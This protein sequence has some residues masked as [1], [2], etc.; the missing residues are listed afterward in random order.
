MAI[1]GFKPMVLKK[2]IN[3]VIDAYADLQDAIIQ[4]TQNQFVTPMA[5]LWCCKEAVEY[6]RNKF[7]PAIDSLNEA[8]HKT[9]KSVVQ[10]M[11]E[12]GISWAKT[13][14]NTGD[15]QSITFNI[16]LKKIDISAIK[17]K[18][19]DGEIGIDELQAVV[20]AGLL[21]TKTFV[22]A[23][24]AV[25]KAQVAVAISGF[26]GGEQEAQLKKSLKSISDSIENTVKELATAAK[27]SIEDSASAYG[28]VAS[29][30]A[31]AF[32]VNSK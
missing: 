8:A 21:L 12:A 26:L 19:A 32:T 13:T 17:D 1:T 15:W 4:V 2:S 11:N 31:S 9:F 22:K 23:Q 14:G 6:F 16:T 29:K 28:T 30:L 25:L 27:Q 3:N 18:T 20:K 24:A 5:N 10:V 7:Q